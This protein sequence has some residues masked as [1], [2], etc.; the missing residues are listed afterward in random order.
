[1]LSDEYRRIPWNEIN[2]DN[3]TDGEHG[4]AKALPFCRA[5]TGIVSKTVPFRAVY[6]SVTAECKKLTK[7]VRSLDKF[8]KNWK[9]FKVTLVVSCGSGIARKGSGNTRKGSDHCLS[10]R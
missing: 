1:M 3:L 4:R 7:I 8:V 5:P 10:K 9:V 6:L 2:T